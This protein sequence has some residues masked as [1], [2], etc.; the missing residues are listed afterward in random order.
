MCKYDIRIMHLLDGQKAPDHATINRFRQRIEPFVEDIL[1]ENNKFLIDSN[2]IDPS[3]I[4]IDGTKIEANA[5][6]Y[7]FVWKKSVEKYKKSLTEKLKKKFSLEEDICYEEII[8]VLE[9]KLKNLEQVIDKDEIEFVYGK[10]KRKTQ[11][12][13]DYEK[14]SDYLNRFKT[15]QEH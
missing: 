13:R 1:E 12:Q 10:G 15:Y 14:V 2:L 11:I 6:K 8:R 7:S 4:Y 9:K 5:N 3:S